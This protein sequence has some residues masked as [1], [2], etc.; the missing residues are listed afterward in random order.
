MVI[1]DVKGMLAYDLFII[2]YQII[3]FFSIVMFLPQVFLIAFSQ[4]SG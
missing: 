4:G 3:A 1:K 2:A